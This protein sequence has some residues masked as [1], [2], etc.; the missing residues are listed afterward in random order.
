METLE[1]NIRAK[2]FVDLAL[3]KKRR[4]D[5]AYWRKASHILFSKQ[6]DVD[7]WLEYTKWKKRP[8]K[9]ENEGFIIKLS[10]LDKK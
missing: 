9:L 5:M 8:Y 3:K 6:Q 2:T 1:L 10:F 4:S 7:D